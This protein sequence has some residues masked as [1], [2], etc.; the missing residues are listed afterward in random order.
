MTRYNL[1]GL[2]YMGSTVGALARDALWEVKEPEI[3]RRALSQCHL[4]LY[5]IGKDKYPEGLQKE[6]RDAAAAL[7]EIIQPLLAEPEIIAALVT[8]SPNIADRYQ[9]FETLFQADLQRVNAFYVPR[10]LGYDMSIL[11]ESGE[12]LILDSLHYLFSDLLRHDLREATRCL[13]FESPTA[14]AFHLGRALEETMRQYQLEF[15][16][17]MPANPQDHSM[18]GLYGIWLN[19][20]SVP[21]SLVENIKNIKDHYRNPISHPEIIV[22][23]AGAHAMIGIYLSTIIDMLT[24]ISVRRPNMSNL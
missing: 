21:R 3:L 16:G 7:K 19:T 14:C 10:V 12:E 5:V 8:Q 4:A 13:A 1:F 11:I 23:T 15:H 6:T 20:S 17:A 2:Y 9:K 22:D 24:Q 18:G